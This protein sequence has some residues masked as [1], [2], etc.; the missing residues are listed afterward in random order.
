MYNNYSHRGT[1]NNSWDVIIVGAGPAGL[2]AALPLVKTGIS[3]L[4]L[5]K[6][7]VI[8][9]PNHCGEGVSHYVLDFLGI[10]EDKN[11]IV[12]KM[13]G[14]KIFFPNGKML[15]YP[16]KSYGIDRTLFDQ[17]L[18]IN[19]IKNGAKILLHKEVINITKNNGLWEIITRNSETF[20]GKYLIAAD[21]AVSTIRRIL[22]I[23]E[24][25]IGGIQYKF[26]H[27][28]KFEDEYFWFYNNEKFQP[29]YAWI[30]DR[31]FETSIGVGGIKNLRSKLEVFLHSLGID[32]NKKKSVHCGGIPNP[33]GP[34]KVI[35]SDVLFAGDAG[36]FVFPL[37]FAGIISALISGRI[38]GETVRDALIEKK[39]DILYTY[40]ERVKSVPCR[41][42]TVLFYSN[43]FF[44][45]PN[46][47]LNAIGK[48]MDKR[49]YSDLPIINAFYIL[50]KNPNWQ[51]VNGLLT[52]F[53]A[54]QILSCY[55]KYVF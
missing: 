50:M 35:L 17:E 48:V 15:Y 39:P 24:N 33:K 29:G 8:G 3:T 16:M 37:T 43:N 32:P 36:G 49:L 47:S 41:S 2:S 25:L 44:S 6:K 20:K 18:A 5:E 23:R 34:M 21:G 22:G 42:K 14:I 54:Q 7:K 31:D 9:F 55:K 53:T 51:T 27:I 13:K 40:T 4:I 12:R 28:K 30:F 1:V 52:G 26:D 19:A 10:S 45:L 46:K 38:A 11:W